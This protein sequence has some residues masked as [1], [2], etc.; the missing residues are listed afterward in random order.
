MF[1]MC[2]STARSETTRMPAI[3]PSGAPFGHQCEHVAFPGGE[4]GEAV[5][6]PAGRH[7]HV[8]DGDVGVVLR[9]GGAQRIGGADGGDDVTAIG[10][11]L[12]EPGQAAARLDPGAAGAIVADPDPKQAAGIVLAQNV[13]ANAKASADAATEP[14]HGQRRARRHSA[15][16]LQRERQARDGQSVISRTVG[17]SLRRSPGSDV[18]TCWLLRRAQITT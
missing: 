2:F 7:P 15:R 5:G 12:G 18:T 17:S 1:E 4:R 3:A 8:H 9:D 6:L 13:G 11:D 14:P 16:D 10:Q